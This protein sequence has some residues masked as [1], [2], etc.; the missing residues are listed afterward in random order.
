MTSDNLVG[1]GLEREQTDREEVERQLVRADRKLI[2]SAQTTISLDSRFDIAYE[3]LLQIA[4]AAR[5]GEAPVVPVAPAQA[6]AQRCFFPTRQPDTDDPFLRRS[7]FSRTAT[8]H[9]RLKPAPDLIGGRTY[10]TSRGEGQGQA[11]AKGRKAVTGGSWFKGR[12]ARQG[13]L[14]DLH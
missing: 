13:G 7:G 4:L 12:G 2:D 9:V 10:G 1:R 8:I 5:V 14:H 11:R 3:A 6:G